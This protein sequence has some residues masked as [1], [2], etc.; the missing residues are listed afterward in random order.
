[1]ANPYEIKLDLKMSEYETVNAAC[2]II[3]EQESTF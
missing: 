3:N 1:M 2:K